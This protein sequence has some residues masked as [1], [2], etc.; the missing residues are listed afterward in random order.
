MKVKSEDILKKLITFYDCN[1]AR[2]TFKKWNLHKMLNKNHNIY[3]KKDFSENTN[4][5]ISLFF[6]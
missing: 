5:E 6:L 3:I 1:V 2:N 4:D